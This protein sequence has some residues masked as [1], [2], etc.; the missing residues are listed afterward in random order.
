MTGA[1]VLTAY[2]EAWP[3]TFEEEARRLRN[4]L[5]TYNLGGL[6]H[7]GSTS[8]PGMIAKPVIDIIAS[9]QDLDKL[10]RRGDKFWAELGYEWG[11]GDND[12]GGWLYFIKRD[13]TGRR[14]IHLHLVPDRSSF[15]RRTI[16]FRDALRLDRIKA[17]EYANLKIR[18]AERFRNDRLGY[19]TGKRDFVAATVHHL[20]SQ[21][22]IE[23]WRE[24][25]VSDPLRILVSAC[26]AG[27]SVGF[28]GS[29]YGTHAEI[30]DII[31]LPN[32]RAVTFCPE[33]FAFGTPRDVC[34]IQGGDGYDVLAG[35]ARVI[36]AGGE[37]WTD[38]TI[39]AAERML[40]IAQGNACEV[41]VLMD[42]SAA[43]ILT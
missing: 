38:R 42:I 10:P 26:L 30:A 8:I 4:A 11:H 17:R 20:P 31:A 23:S 1:I 37:D 34:D 13:N 19:L 22:T 5:A 32:V 29:T 7:V 16:L 18:L 9:V 2:D 3:R 36:S 27:I 21:E 35:R 39:Q 43:C 24:F 40:D 41:A 33:D 15:W 12:D 14:L 6:E 28:D 25:T